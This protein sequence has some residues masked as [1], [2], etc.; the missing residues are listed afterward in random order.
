M[1]PRVSA[2][3]LVAGACVSFA[4]LLL[5]STAVAADSHTWTSQA[6]FQAGTLVNLDATS[7]PGSLTLT[8]NMNPLAF[9][10]YTGNPVFTANSSGWDNMAVIPYTVLG[11]AGAWTMWYSGLNSTSGG[12]GRATSADGIHW[13][14]DP[15][16]PILNA[17][18]W[19]NVLD[20][21]GTY[22]MW[23]QSVSAPYQPTAVEYAT[24]AD[25]I[26]WTPYS[27]NP[28][29]SPSASAFDSLLVAP[30]GVVH[31]AS[32]YRMWYTGN[33][34]SLTYSVG[35]ATSPDGIHWTKYSGNPII[36]PGFGGAYDGERVIACNVLPWN[37]GLLMGYVGAD[38]GFVQR[39][40]MA[41]SAD[42]IHWTP[43]PG[44]TLDV[45][46]SGSWDDLGLSRMAIAD[47]GGNLTMWY[48]GSSS[49]G[50]WETG[51]ATSTS[52]APSYASVGTFASTVFD[53]GNANT[54]WVSLAWVGSTPAGTA[55]GAS[56]EVGNTSHPDLTWTLSPP[57]VNASVTLRL[58]KARY[59][60]VIV[61]MVTGDPSQTPTLDSIA[62]TYQPPAPVEFGSLGFLGLILL[63]ALIAGAAAAFLVVLLLAHRQKPVQGVPAPSA[64]SMPCPR[65]G[66]AVPPGNSY[67]GSCGAPL[68]S[69]GSGT[70]PKP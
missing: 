8:R 2:R 56:V 45:G 19:P 47:V 20:E 9:S 66:A 69:S 36:T 30:G 7:S 48:G 14:R 61:A 53:S 55:I 54:T 46:P 18:A 52:T 63:I 60:I 59:A 25:G 21:S 6:D 49:S 23:Y 28:V 64:A 43:V 16:Y 62:I 32:G 29:L 4:I 44:P 11:G 51:L 57:S 35:L 3:R 31:D 10:P 34:G 33:N 58:P 39:I 40:A 67:C 17:S 22:K 26:H 24:S 42:G 70:P 27:G 38:S 13:T 5:V 15:V 37:G 68:A 12:I 65:C 1:S 41:T 50:Y